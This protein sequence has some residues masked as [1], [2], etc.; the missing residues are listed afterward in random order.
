[1]KFRTLIRPFT[2]SGLTL[3]FVALAGCSDNAQDTTQTAAAMPR[4][5]ADAVEQA[6]ARSEK[7]VPI[8]DLDPLLTPADAARL[9]GLDPQKAKRNR[10]D[11]PVN[12]LHYAWSSS[13]KR[14]LPT[15][16]RL[17]VDDEIQIFQ[18]AVR[19]S[20]TEEDFRRQHLK[21]PDPAAVQQA[22][23]GLRASR[24]YQGM[25]RDQQEMAE[26]MLMGAA[27]RPPMQAVEGVGKAAAWDSRTST[28][29]VLVDHYVMV[30][31]ASLADDDQR[32]R[33]V[34]IELAQSAID[35][36]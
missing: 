22:L 10:L 8:L 28:L 3:L 25:P 32:N 23:E 31:M 21:A 4:S 36:L 16:L 24:R 29:Y 35:R 26:K 20:T 6:N 14:Q 12:S 7:A 13:R 19:V 15:G 27:N 17:P 30:T 2:L 1:M 9:T 33:S 34:A 18:P 5:A 11:K